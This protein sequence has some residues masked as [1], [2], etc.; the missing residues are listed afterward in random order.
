MKWKGWIN[1]ILGLWLLI[2]P[3]LGFNPRGYFW[4][5]LIVGVIVATAGF[6]MVQKNLWQG[7]ITGFLGAWL[8]IAAFIPELMR[9]I[10]L[11]LNSII[12]GL[13]IAASGLIVLTHNKES[14]LYEN[15]HMH[16]GYSNYG[17]E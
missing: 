6:C 5:D 14:D 15:S 8:V 10:G 9:G 11:Y 13:T 2:A 7:W 1:S 4:N 12:I 17:K 16:F 3:F